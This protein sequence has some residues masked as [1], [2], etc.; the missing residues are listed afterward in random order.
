MQER[1]IE[2]AAVSFHTQYIPEKPKEMI[3]DLKQFGMCIARIMYAE[4][5]DKLQPVKQA[6]PTVEDMF[7]IS[8]QTVITV[9]PGTGHKLVLQHG[10][11]APDVVTALR[12]AYNH[13]TAAGRKE[14]SRR[15]AAK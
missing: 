5:Q 8:T 14:E 15:L 4:Q 6:E 9:I 10:T 13:G 1:D 12:I 7:P 11:V 3:A 2:S